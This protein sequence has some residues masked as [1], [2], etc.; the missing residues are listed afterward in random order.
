YDTSDSRFR[1]TDSVASGRR[2][3]ENGQMTFTA[4]ALRA[5][6]D[7]GRVAKRGKSHKSG[8]RFTFNLWSRLNVKR[9]R[10]IA[11]CLRTLFALILLLFGLQTAPVWAGLPSD[12]RPTRTA[13][14]GV[15]MPPPQ[16]LPPAQGAKFS[17]PD[18]QMVVPGSGAAYDI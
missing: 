3:C 7:S 13:L 12:F 17:N 4:K 18:R 2:A 14:S 6:F 15:L 8:G 11:T 9:F 10:Q 5:T 16:A 1:A